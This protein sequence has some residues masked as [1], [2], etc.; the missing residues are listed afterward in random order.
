MARHSSGEQH[1]D[2]S[3]GLGDPSQIGRP[4]ST[5]EEYDQLIEREVQLARE[6]RQHGE[7]SFVDLGDLLQNGLPPVKFLPGELARNLAYDAGVTLLSGH[8]GA[9]K[10]TFG[11]GC[12]L[13]FMRAGGHVIYHDWENGDVETARS[14][15]D[16]GAPP[17]LLSERL[18]YIPFPDKPDWEQLED[19]WDRWPG[20]LGVW[21]SLRGV[22]NVMGLDED[23]APDCARFFNPLVR[24]CLERRIANIVIDHVRKD[25]TERSYY[26]R[27]SGDK[28][29]AVQASWFVKTT[30]PF[31]DTQAGEIM[32]ARWKARSGHMPLRHRFAVGDGRGNLTFA[33]LNA[34]ETDEGRIEREIIEGLKK[35]AKAQSKKQ[36]EDHVGGNRA[37]TRSVLEKLALREATPVR[38]VYPK[39][40]S[41]E[42]AKNPKYEYVAADDFTGS[43]WANAKFTVER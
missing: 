34:G 27:G 9:G 38:E 35:A 11:R 19:I 18:H 42:L 36:V 37:N 24:F 40:R 17:E 5:P 26:G 20:S 7:P 30:R 31:S 32:L 12:S 16:L 10:S 22:M 6:Q 1:S 2:T 28:A 21:D 43:E 14:Y 13:D 15:R 39:L 4:Y 33:R 29:A 25:A 3:N 23:R 8:P 41:G